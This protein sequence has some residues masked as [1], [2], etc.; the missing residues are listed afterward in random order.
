MDYRNLARYACVCGRV[1]LVQLWW[2]ASDAIWLCAGGEDDELCPRCG[3][4][5]DPWRY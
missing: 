2:S 5:G 1:W 4:W 3:E